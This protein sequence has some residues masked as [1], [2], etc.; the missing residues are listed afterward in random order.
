MLHLTKNPEHKAKNW[1]GF[2]KREARKLGNNI[3][4]L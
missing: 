1:V 4:Y 2:Q 3:F